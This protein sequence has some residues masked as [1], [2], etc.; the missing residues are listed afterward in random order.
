MLQNT[1]GH[2]ADRARQ[3]QNKAV[4]KQQLRQACE[5]SKRVKKPPNAQLP[6]AGTNLFSI[7]IA[8]RKM[9]GRSP[10]EPCGALDTMGLAW[11][12]LMA[13]KGAW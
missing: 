5:K 11:C 2:W 4:K 10:V 3:G 7:C 8:C 6:L 9:R 13:D 12:S 1:Q